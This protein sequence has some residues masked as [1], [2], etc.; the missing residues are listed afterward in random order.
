[1]KPWYERKVFNSKGHAA[2]FNL[3]VLFQFSFDCRDAHED[4]EYFQNIHRI[5]AY[6]DRVTH[7]D[8]VFGH[9]LFENKGT[10]PKKDALE[11]YFVAAGTSTTSDSKC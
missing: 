8:T 7:I 5:N 11:I 10:R 3:R 1:M 9:P 2:L 6:L 4:Y